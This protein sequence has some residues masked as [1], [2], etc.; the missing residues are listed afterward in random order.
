MS[1]SRQEEIIAVLW[2]IAALLAFNGGH[3]II[4][5][6]LTVKFAFDT[7]CSLAF[8]LLEIRKEKSK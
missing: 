1:L 4:G 5:S 7:V 6:V 3:P 2:L 8:A